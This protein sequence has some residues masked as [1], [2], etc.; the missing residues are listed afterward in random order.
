MHEPIYGCKMKL[1]NAFMRELSLFLSLSSYTHVQVV[2]I[3]HH[4]MQCFFF[5]FFLTL[6]TSN[7]HRYLC[8][9]C[10]LLLSLKI[11]KIPLFHMKGGEEEIKLALRKLLEV[12]LCHN[13]K[14]L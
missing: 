7:L 13:L 2:P 11:I 1:K 9:D 8:D 6:T 4:Q 14:F 5:F 3:V 12:C 10:E